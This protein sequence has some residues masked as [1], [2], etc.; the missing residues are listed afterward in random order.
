MNIMPE[1][2]IRPIADRIETHLR[3][4]SPHVGQR[5]QAKLL[6]EAMEEIRRLQGLVDKHKETGSIHAIQKTDPKSPKWG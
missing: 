3:N 6:R 4:L 5:M 1:N 2:S